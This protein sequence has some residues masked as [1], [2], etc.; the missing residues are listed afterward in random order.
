MEHISAELRAVVY[1]PPV[2]T[3]LIMS[4]EERAILTW[5]RIHQKEIIQAEMK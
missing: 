5:L 3:Q 4:S 1:F 2:Q